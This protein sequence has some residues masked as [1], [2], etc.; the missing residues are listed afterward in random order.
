MRKEIEMDSWAKSWSEKMVVGLNC[1]GPTFG[2]FLALN[3]NPQKFV[4]QPCSLA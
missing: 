1:G 4:Q 2:F 3:L